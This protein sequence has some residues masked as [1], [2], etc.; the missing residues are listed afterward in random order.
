MAIQNQKTAA[1]TQQNDP[2]PSFDPPSEVIGRKP[3]E[4]QT[5][6]QSMRSGKCVKPAGWELCVFSLRFFTLILAPPGILVSATT[7]PC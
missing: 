7:L 5:G 6:S 2:R 4:T 3:D 1:E